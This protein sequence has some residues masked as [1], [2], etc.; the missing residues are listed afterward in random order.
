MAPLMGWGVFLELLFPTFPFPHTG[1]VPCGRSTK[2]S[3]RLWDLPWMASGPGLAP[4][5]VPSTH[6]HTP[7]G[8]C[9]PSALQTSA[10]HH[11]APQPREQTVNYQ[12]S[13]CKKP[14]RNSFCLVAAVMY[15]A[16]CWFLGCWPHFPP[17][18]T[19]SDS[20]VISCVELGKAEAS[21]GLPQQNLPESSC[22]KSSPSPQPWQTPR[23]IPA[24]GSWWEAVWGA[25]AHAQQPR[26][27]PWSWGCQGHPLTALPILG[28]SPSV[29]TQL[30]RARGAGPGSKLL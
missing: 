7:R 13:S 3:R 19:K 26:P 15:T 21:L 24:A 18:S 20:H 30:R 10:S 28:C 22:P 12:P 4:Y 23:H 14:Q 9:P 25:D 11:F 6:T 27:A 17:P 29:E 8:P 1:C 16:L 2:V 5:R